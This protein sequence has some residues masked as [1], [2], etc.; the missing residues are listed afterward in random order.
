MSEN[1]KYIQYITLT[2]FFSVGG[3]VYI[4]LTL[5]GADMMHGEAMPSFSMDSPPPIST[6][7]MCKDTCGSQQ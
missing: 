4:K 1:Y 3:V 5:A 2:I 6:V 7:L